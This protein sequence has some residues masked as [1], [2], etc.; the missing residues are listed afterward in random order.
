MSKSKRKKANPRTRNMGPSYHGNYSNRDFICANCRKTHRGP[1]ALEC[2]GKELM[3]EIP[4]GLKVPSDKA[5]KKVWLTFL[6]QTTAT[7][8]RDE[9]TELRRAIQT[10]EANFDGVIG[11]IAAVQ[12]LDNK[13]QSQDELDTAVLQLISSQFG[14]K[15]GV[16][17]LRKTAD[18]IEHDILGRDVRY[19]LA[20]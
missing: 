19:A 8:R 4:A 15:R 7:R 14:K 2:C 17:I 18:R 16:E 3:H 10:R 1:A 9:E 5:P 20:R 11:A 13:L 12:W 6:A